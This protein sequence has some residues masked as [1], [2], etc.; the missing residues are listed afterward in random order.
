MKILSKTV[1]EIRGGYLIGQI[2]AIANGAA[3]IKDVVIVDPL[4][5]K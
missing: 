2:A 1:M 3:E 5:E 4:P